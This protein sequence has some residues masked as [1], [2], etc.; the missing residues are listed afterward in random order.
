MRAAI[1]PCR[2]GTDTS[3]VRT[4]RE[5]AAALAGQASEAELRR[6]TDQLQTAL[7]RY[8]DA[9]DARL[10]QQPPAARPAQA[11]PT[12]PAT[13]PQTM[14]REELQA[15]VDRL[16]TLTETG[17]RESAGQLLAQLQELMDNLRPS[18]S[19]EADADAPA[20][21]LL[22]QLT[23]L[24]EQQQRLLDDHC[25]DRAVGSTDQLEGGYFAHLVHRHR[26]DD[27]RDD[28]RAYRQQN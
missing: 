13:A 8:L 17:A 21:P 10:G 9:L 7:D 25:R 23:Q 2:P 26:V 15:L 14:R 1:A 5:L 20:W 27:Q 4:A 11:R 22:Q 19:G 24:T 3:S 6:L 28:Y 12:D 18:P 16:R